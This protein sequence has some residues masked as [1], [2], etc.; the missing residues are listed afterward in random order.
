MARAAQGPRHFFLI[1]PN[2]HSVYPDKLPEGVA[3]AQERPVHQLIGRL[4]DARVV[5]ARGL[6][7]G[8]AR[9]APRARLRED[10]LA[11]DR[12]RRLCRRRGAAGGDPA[13]AAPRCPGAGLLRA[14]WRSPSSGISEPSCRRRLRRPYI[15]AEAHAPRARLV[16]DNRVRNTG[17]RFVYESDAEDGPECPRL[18]RLVRAA[19]A[20]VP[21]REL[22]RDSRSCTWSTSTVDLVRTAPPR[23]RREDHE[24]ALPDRRAGGRPGEDAGRAGG[25]AARRRA[26]CCRRNSSRRGRA[27]RCR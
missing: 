11:L 26:K 25:G 16:S 14:S 13:G 7:A 3:S 20:A 17:R 5:R 24:R 12:I 23:R 27:A 4:R 19:G 22:P 9:L 15:R 8:G 1:A 18:R 6:S 2:A 10:G 21:R